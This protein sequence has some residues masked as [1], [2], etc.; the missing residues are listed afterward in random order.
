MLDRCDL[1]Q[2]LI[3]SRTKNFTFLQSDLAKRREE[4]TMS[5]PFGQQAM[6][7]VARVFAP[8]TN[9]MHPVLGEN[10]AFIPAFAIFF[11]QVFSVS[12]LWLLYVKVHLKKAPFIASCAMSR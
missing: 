9:F 5:L 6:V 2:N 4:I 12:L 11:L 1:L 7:H 3:T 8:L 10:W